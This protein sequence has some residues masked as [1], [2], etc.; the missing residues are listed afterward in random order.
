MRPLAI[1]R[2]SPRS[3]T[4]ARAW[5]LCRAAAEL[6]VFKPDGKQYEEMAKIKV[7]DTPIYAHPVLA[8]NRIFIKDA[9][10]VAMLTVQ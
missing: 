8:G 1:A 4:A 2:A 5:W 3:W 7:S 9:E 6:V 10:S